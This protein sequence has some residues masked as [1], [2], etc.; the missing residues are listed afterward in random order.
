LSDEA[1]LLVQEEIMRVSTAAVAPALATPARLRILIYAGVWIVILNLVS[2]A[3]GFQV[4]PFSFI[5]KNKLHLSANELATFSL[6]AG[7]P[8]YLSFAFGVVRDYWSPL[9]LGDRGYF[10]LFGA[11]AA[12]TWAVFAFVPVSLAM[13]LAASVLATVCFLFMWGGWNGLGSVIGQRYA[14]SGQISALWN[15]AGTLTIFS[16]LLFGGFLSDGLELQ[17]TGSAVRIL[18]LLMATALAAI[19]L[20]GLWKP[21]AVYAH[22]DGERADRRDLL[23]DLKRL[24]LHRPIYPAL[25]IWLAWNFSP[26]GSTVLQYYMS[27]TLHASDAQWGAY[28]A[29]A[30]I[31][32]VPAFI[33]FGF[34]SPRFS[35]ARLL[36]WGT[37]AAVPQMTPLLLVHSVGAVLVA[38]GVIGLLGGVATAA[39]MDLL[40][41]SC[42][43]G[44]E[45]TMMMMSW[46]LFALS[47][48]VGNYLGTWLY[49]AGGFVVCIAA[50]T[51]VYALILPLLLLIPRRLIASADGEQVAE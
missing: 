15:F 21:S 41:R 45:G 26:G 17:G 6:W 14:M 44:L 49:E 28:N 42:P 40:I 18:F 33:L 20:T 34:L 48:N 46:S 29:I 36:L 37:L 1:A 38:A 4:I 35:L 12:A 5:L 39:Y 7:I 23:A 22:L 13:M 10:I 8:G 47:T 51:A 11:L 25:A 24:F 3:S 50:T 30:S 16:G 2:P 9:R 31:A 32:A 43:K 27:N 19:A